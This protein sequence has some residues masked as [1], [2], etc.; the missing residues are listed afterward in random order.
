ME[1]SC[2]GNDYNLRSKGAP[3]TNDKPS[4][5]KTNNKNSSSKQAYTDK[6]LE[7]EKEKETSKEKEKERE[8][9]PSRT[10]ISLDLTQKILG[11]LKLD[12]DVV[13][14]LKKMKANITV[15]ELC[16]IT[17]LREQLRDAL[18]HIQGPQDVVNVI[19]K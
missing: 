17:Q 1:E 7:K 11:D 14:D 2:I 6:S 8:V 3:K 19:Q 13:E 18:Q 16:K 4:T 9:T 5:S 12:Y 10:P 15:F